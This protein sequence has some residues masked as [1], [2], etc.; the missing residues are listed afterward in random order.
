MLSK[1]PFPA[2]VQVFQEAPVLG[3]KMG[4]L[5]PEF[6]LQK[7]PGHPRALSY[8]ALVRLAMGQGDVA[9]KMLKQALQ[10]RTP[11][12]AAAALVDGTQLAKADAR[13]ALTDGGVA[14]VAGS[15]DP[16]IQLARVVDPLER[17]RG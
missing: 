7:Q 12:A 15:A 2:A 11:E 1:R 5:D 10:G 6:V 9:E 8:Q 14:A 3:W 13:K 4:R 16:L 17:A